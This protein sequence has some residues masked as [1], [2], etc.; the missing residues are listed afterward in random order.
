M[1]EDM[2]FTLSKF[3]ENQLLLTL[4]DPITPCHGIHI[5]KDI[6]TVCFQYNDKY[7]ERLS[8]LECINPYRANKIAKDNTFICF[9][10]YLS[11]KIRLDISCE[12]SASA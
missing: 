6:Y 5:A 1:L 7:N 4:F 2:V 12:S 9:Y 10:F 11:K 3:N 8:F